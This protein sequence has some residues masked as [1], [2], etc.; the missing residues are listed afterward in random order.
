MRRQ[1][2]SLFG[3]ARKGFEGH[4]VTYDRNGNRTRDTTSGNQV[5]RGADIYLGTNTAGNLVAYTLENYESSRYN[6][7]YT[8]ALERSRL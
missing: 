3:D 5:S 7:H 8:M 1:T 4:K 6:N 2:W